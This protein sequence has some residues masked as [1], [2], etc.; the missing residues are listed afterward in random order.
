MLPA[1]LILLAYLI[2]SIP[3]SYLIGR[4]FGKTDI[5]RVGS[6]NVGATNVAR[7]VGKAAG[8]LALVLDLVK[9]CS[10]IWLARMITSRPDWPWH[11]GGQSLL[12]S[13]SFWMGLSGLVAVIGHMA[14]IWLRFQGGKGV[15][16]AGGVFLAINP[17]A[18]AAAAILFLITTIL[19]RFVSLGSIVAAASIPL[20]LRFLTR[21]TFWIIIFSIVIAVLVILKHH[22]N[23]ARMARGDEHRFP[24]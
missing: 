21:E 17:V 9:G 1:A 14:P 6:G 11:Y 12:A 16:T 2:G 18:T 23:I 4:I 8:A 10:V 24:S 7:S 20:I 5:R 15:A 22:R 19:T 3:F 13:Q